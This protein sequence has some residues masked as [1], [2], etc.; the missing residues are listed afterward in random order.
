[1]ERPEEPRVSWRWLENEIA[2][3]MSPL[4]WEH[5]WKLSVYRSLISRNVKMPVKAKRK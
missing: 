3:R 4:V 2:I 5:T 1:V